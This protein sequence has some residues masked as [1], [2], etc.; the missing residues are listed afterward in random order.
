MTLQEIKNAVD[1]GLTV[2]YQS[3]T[4]TIVKENDIYYVESLSGHRVR[5]EWPN[6]KGLNV[7]PE[8]CF[9]RDSSN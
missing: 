2:C 5:L 8:L 4:Y 3:L 1:S 7:R 6:G 9:I